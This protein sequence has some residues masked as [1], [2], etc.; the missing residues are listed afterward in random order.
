[1]NQEPSAQARRAAE[2]LACAIRY[3]ASSGEQPSE[4]IEDRIAKI[5]TGVGEA[6]EL[7]ERLCK[8]LEELAIADPDLMRTEI[9]AQHFL[10]RFKQD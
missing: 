3:A 9:D 4:G 8:H 2:E 5:E 10:A 6:A 7:I 1:M